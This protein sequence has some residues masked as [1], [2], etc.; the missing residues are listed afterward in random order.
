MTE[1]GVALAA[2]RWGVV[3]LRTILRL[4]RRRVLEDV[5]I[6][7]GLLDIEEEDMDYD[8]RYKH[9]PIQLPTVTFTIVV[10]KRIY[11]ELQLKKLL[12]ELTCDSIPLKTFFYDR[13]YNME[14][15]KDSP[16]I[17]AE[18]IGAIGDGK[19][20]IRY[21]CVNIFY[22]HDYVHKWELVGRVT[23]HSKIGD[24]NKRRVK[25]I[26][27]LD[28]KKEEK[29]KKAIKDFQKVYVEGAESKIHI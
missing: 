5:E 15:E 12:F 13:S 7:R 22:N 18:D 14:M 26:F 16:D 21:P 29:L 24:I 2:T 8:I 23:Y 25:L 20:I 1:L 27:Q 3:L 19:I 11:L 9:L 4:W 28:N 17:V 6:S 10:K